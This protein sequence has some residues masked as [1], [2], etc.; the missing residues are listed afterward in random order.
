[1]T[2]LYIGKNKITLIDLASSTDNSNTEVSGKLAIEV[3]NL[4]Q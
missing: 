2:V 1:M 4:V 3:K